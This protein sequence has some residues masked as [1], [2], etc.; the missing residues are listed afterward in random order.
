MLEVGKIYN[1]FKLIEKSRV[2]EIDSEA[3]IFEHVKTEAKLL[4]LINK[5]DNIQK[6]DSTKDIDNTIKPTFNMVL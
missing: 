3:L 1:G 6:I 2:E 5:D 4:K